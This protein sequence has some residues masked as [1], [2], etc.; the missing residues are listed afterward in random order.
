[1][2]EAGL[3][4]PPPPA[5]PVK[6]LSRAI[7]DGPPAMACACRRLAKKP[8][9][10]RPM[11]TTRAICSR[12]PRKPEKPL[13]PWNMP[14]PNSSPPMPAPINPPIRPD[15]NGDRPKKLDEAAAGAPKPGDGVGVACGVALRCIGAAV[16]GA[17]L[18]AGGAV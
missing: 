13:M 7:I 11:I 17:V 8:Q 6:S 9:I 12:K 10:R 3:P 1:A 14:P 15:M 18:V 2:L 5:L 4:N 16:P